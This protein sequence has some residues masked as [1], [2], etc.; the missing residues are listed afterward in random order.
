[1][2]AGN[3][4]VATDNPHK[5]RRVGLHGKRI[6]SSMPSRYRQHTWHILCL[7][8][9]RAHPSPLRCSLHPVPS[10]GVQRPQQAQPHCRWTRLPHSRSA[11]AL[12]AR[13]EP[14]ERPFRRFTNVISD[15]Q[16]QQPFLRGSEDKA[17][18][19]NRAVEPN[20][21]LLRPLPL[22]YDE[23][24]IVRSRAACESPSCVLCHH[25]FRSRVPGIGAFASCLT[26][27]I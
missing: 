9:F 4:G 27:C 12:L 26:V 1:M 16:P 15:I 10:G 17:P 2:P 13:F 20:S 22:R 21:A 24:T 19:M 14:L 6:A 3:L 11:S 8:V 5:R 25:A 23:L 7:L 18:E